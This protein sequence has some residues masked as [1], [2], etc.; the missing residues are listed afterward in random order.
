MAKKLRSGAKETTG[1]SYHMFGFEKLEVCQ[2]ALEF[3]DAEE[4]SQ[5]SGGRIQGFLSSEDF[6]I[7]HNAANEQGGLLS[8]L[9]RS[10]L[11][12]V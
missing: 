4:F 2:R 6:Q 1:R 7:R 11:E 3:A 9:R 10:T 8:G 12:V 5:C